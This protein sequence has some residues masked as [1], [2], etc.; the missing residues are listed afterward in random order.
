MVFGVLADGIT[1]RTDLILGHMVKAGFC[2][3]DPASN[4][5]RNMDQAW[6]VPL[7]RV[8]AEMVRIDPLR[9]ITNGLHLRSVQ[10]P[11]V[12]QIHQVY[13]C[14]SQL[15]DRKAFIPT[16]CPSSLAVGSTDS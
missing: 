14:M 5:V 15:M 16:S 2:L 4:C 1:E 11:A 13:R 7:Q 3:N 10:T 9:Y 12:G 6:P 8:G